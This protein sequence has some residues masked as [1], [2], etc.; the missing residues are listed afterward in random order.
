MCDTGGDVWQHAHSESHAPTEP[1]PESR[2]SLHLS[3]SVC[4]GSQLVR[5]NRTRWS[6]SLVQFAMCLAEAKPNVC[7]DWLCCVSKMHHRAELCSMCCVGGG[8]SCC[9]CL[10]SENQVLA[11]SM[12]LGCHTHPWLVVPCS[13][14]TTLAAAMHSQAA[15]SP[16]VT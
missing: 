16:A 9:L 14:S 2:P 4:A 5:S 1:E 3:D 13:C 7:F 8:V 15:A 6:G 10:T 12:R 11:S